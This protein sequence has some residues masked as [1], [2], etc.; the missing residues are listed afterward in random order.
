NASVEARIDI[1]TT[2]DIK[3]TLSRA[4]ALSQQSISGFLLEAAFERAKRVLK[5]HE[6]ITLSNAERD[7]FFALLETSDEPNDELK[8]AMSE[9][10]EEHKK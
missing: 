9:Y 1:K 4:A 10:F 5:E 6:T 8:T 7:R 3:N 2:P